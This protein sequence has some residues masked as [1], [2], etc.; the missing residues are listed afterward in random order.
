MAA[1]DTFAN[2]GSVIVHVKNTNGAARIVTFNDPNSVGPGSAV[3]FDPDVS[4]TVPATTGERLIGPFPVSRFSDV[5]S[6][7]WD[8]DTGVTIAV[9]Q[10]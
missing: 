3:A 1:G 9:L 8:F 4:V 6:M 7:T 2:N 10:Y 5:V